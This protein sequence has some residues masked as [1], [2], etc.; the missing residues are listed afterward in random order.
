MAI[1]QCPICHQRISSLAKACQ[2]CGAGLGEMTPQKRRQMAAY[3]HKR[4]SAL[5]KKVSLVALA[6]TFAGALNWWFEAGAGWEW[7]PSMMAVILLVA[8]LSLYLV[9]R[10]WLLWLH[11]TRSTVK[12]LL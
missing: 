7:P 10:G 9:G 3:R 4:Q 2:H 5:A 11:L 8:G 12:R 1:I 6:I